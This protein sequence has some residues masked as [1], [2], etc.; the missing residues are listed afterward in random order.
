[1]FDAMSPGRMSAGDHEFTFKID[2]FGEDFFQVAEFT[3][4]EGM[5]QLFELD[6][7]LMCTDASIA[8]GKAVGKTAVFTSESIIGERYFHGIVSE[9][10]VA[11]RGRTLVRYR[12]KVVPRL[13]LLSRRRDSRIFQEMSTPDILKAV[14]EAAGVSG[15]GLDMRLNR[16]YSARDY[17]VQYRETDLDFACRLMEEEGIAYYFAHSASGHKLVL[18]DDAIAHE[19]LDPAGLRFL[20]SAMSGGAGQH[21]ESLSLARTI[22]PGKATLRDFNFKGPSESLEVSVEYDGTGASIDQ[23]PG[24][25]NTDLEFYDFPGEYVD[26]SLG[27]ELA[28]LRLEQLQVQ[29]FRVDGVSTARRLCPGFQVVVSGH[30]R[31]GLNRTYLVTTVT[32]L[33]TQPVPDTPDDDRGE[34]TYRNHFTAIPSE[35]SFRPP[36]TTPRPQVSGLQ[37]AIVTGPAGEEIHTDEYGRVK[38]QFHWDRLGQRDDQSSC[39]V[40]VSHPSAGAGYGQIILPRVGQEVIIQFLEGDPDRPI[41][42]GRLYNGEQTPPAALPDGKTRSS[43]KSNTYPGG[44]GYNELTFEDKAGAEEIVLHGQKDAAFTIEN[45][46]TTSIGNNETHGVKGNRS[47]SVDGNEDMA[48]KGNQSA[49]VKGNQT[50]SVEGNRSASVK[51][52]E[53]MSVK[54]NQSHAVTGNRTATI[55]GNDTLTVTGT[56]TTT[57]SGGQASLNVTGNYS[58]SASANLDLSAGASGSFSAASSLSASSA[59][60]SVSGSSDVTI[61]SGGTITLVVGSSSIE[62]TDSEIKIMSPKVSI[63]ND[64][65]NLEGSKVSMKGSEEVGISGGKVNSNADTV[66]SVSGATV[67]LN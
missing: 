50:E 44:G 23:D 43:I 21:I 60:V 39:W 3:A 24:D 42:T 20:P 25:N 40:R 27:N 31:S 56:S 9:I 35:L 65:V 37:T 22:Q 33:G 6:L 53:D 49:S 52:N 58:A 18:S 57:V 61:S 8:L 17:C 5:S 34:A 45:D 7:L 64:E 19:E 15:D 13:W 12:V 26:K 51:G 2:G 46:Q 16:N 32:H 62:I 4:T 63:G 38:I 55:T 54:G 10:Q 59:S 14:F 48:V 66:N 30:A 67:K 29:R 11:G 47:A 41:V 36:L 28:R 1:M